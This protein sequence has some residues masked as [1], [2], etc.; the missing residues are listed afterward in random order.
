[1]VA[2]APPEVGPVG[3]APA[4]P[5][6]EELL[7]SEALDVAA[8]DAV[9]LVVEVAEVVDVLGL[10]L[11]VAPPGTVSDGVGVVSAEV[12]APPPPQPASAAARATPAPSAD[13]HRRLTIIRALSRESSL[14]PPR[15]L[16]GR[17]VAQRLHP[18]AAMR[19]VVEILWL[20]LV[21]PVA[22]AQILDRPGEVGRG[23]RQRQQL[24]DDL[25]PLARLAIHVHAIGFGFDDH[26][27]AGRGR[28]HP[29]LL[30]RPH[31]AASYRE[32]G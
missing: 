19:A 25:K 22:E 5:F 11:A 24:S 17:S 23:W 20:E 26:L 31:P 13:S 4:V 15:C 7:G 28:P 6:E 2:L 18:P 12:L 27:T 8:D 14:S 10:T 3:A 9:V 1:L 30:A 21:A 32:L 29:I 16:P